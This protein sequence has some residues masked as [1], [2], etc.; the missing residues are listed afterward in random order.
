M[1]FSSNLSDLLNNKYSYYTINK[2]VIFMDNS[3]KNKFESYLSQIMKNVSYKDKN[4]VYKIISLL[5][6]WNRN[7]NTPDIK[8]V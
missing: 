8:V 7:V 3:M 6:K 2:A 5:K 1:C 4:L